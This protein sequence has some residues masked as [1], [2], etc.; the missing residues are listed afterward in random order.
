MKWKRII[1]GTVLALFIN[2]V[3]GAADDPDITV[4]ELEW[5]ASIGKDIVWFSDYD[6][7]GSIGTNTYVYNDDT[8]TNSA[9]TDGQVECRN[10]DQSKTIQIS[11]STLGSTSIDVRGEGRAGT[12][13]AWF[14]IHTENFSAATTIDF[15]MPV[16]EYVEEIR[17]GARSNGTAGTDVI[18]ITGILRGERK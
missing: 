8:G 4:T 12:D 15:G 10:Y 9:N 5:R 3:A 16:L 2:G 14:E 6:L 18:T 7:G 17:V 1:V 13:T 11:I